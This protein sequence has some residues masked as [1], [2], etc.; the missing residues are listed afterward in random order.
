MDFRSLFQSF[1]FEGSGTI[2]ETIDLIK[3]SGIDPDLEVI[4]FA[5]CYKL[6]EQELRVKRL[7]AFRELR[8]FTI[9]ELRGKGNFK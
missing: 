7:E 8:S 3:G 6:Y 5:L 4:F 9:A 1:S 2:K